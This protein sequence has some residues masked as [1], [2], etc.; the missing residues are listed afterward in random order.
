M[1]QGAPRQAR[2]LSTAIPLIL[3]HGD[4]DTT[5]SPHNADRILDQWLQTTSAGDRSSNRSVREIIVEPGQVASGHAYTRAIY[6]NTTGRTI[7]EKWVI[8]QAGHAWSGGSSNGS[9]T[10]SKGPDASAAMM[11]FFI[12]HPKKN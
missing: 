2:P 12:D 9:F 5:V 4:S 11:R 3:F 7:A 10:D 1:K 8:H 6:V